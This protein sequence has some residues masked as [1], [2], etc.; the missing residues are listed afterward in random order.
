VLV[1]YIGGRA[2]AGGTP[3]LAS[4]NGSSHQDGTSTT[5]TP[6]ITSAIYQPG[7]LLTRVGFGHA[8]LEWDYPGAATAISVS[9]SSAIGGPLAVTGTVTGTTTSSTYST[10]VVQEKLESIQLADVYGL[11]AT[12]TWD[13][14]VAGS[15]RPRIHALTIPVTAQEPA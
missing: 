1:P 2:N 7:G 8:V 10:A 14:A 15:E 13:T 3:Y 5:F 6:S 11:Q 12:I 9:V 4:F